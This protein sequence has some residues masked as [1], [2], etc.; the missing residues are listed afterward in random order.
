MSRIVSARWRGSSAR[1][2]WP[3]GA[4]SQ[5][6]QR[7]VQT[8]DHERCRTF[9]KHSWMSN[10]PFAD[11][12]QAIRAQL[13]SVR[14][15]VAGRNAHTQLGLRSTGAAGSNS[16]RLRDLVAAER[17]SPCTVAVKARPRMLGDTETMP[18]HG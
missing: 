4:T 18:V 1:A 11:G 6:E 7:R 13:I 3:A 5:N 2:A 17:L 16:A 15:L 14:G 10:R 8:E 9:P 12:D